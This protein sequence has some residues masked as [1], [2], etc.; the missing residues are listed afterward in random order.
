M[1]IKENPVIS[2]EYIEKN[3]IHKDIIKK[4]LEKQYELWNTSGKQ[5]EY[6]QE[7]VNE[8]VQILEE[9]ENENIN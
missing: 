9:T 8:L 5:K 7:I 6:S 1:E 4:H 3:Y 2:R